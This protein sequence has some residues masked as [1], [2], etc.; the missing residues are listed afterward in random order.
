MA[1]TDQP[2][3]AYPAWLKR[4]RVPVTVIVGPHGNGVA[5][6]LARHAGPSDLVI[7]KHAIMAKLSGRRPALSADWIIPA[8]THRNAELAKLATAEGSAGVNR[9]WLIEQSPRDWQRRFWADRL[10]ADIVVLDPGIETA[11]AAA[12]AEGWEARWVDRWYL[13]AAMLDATPEA[14]ASSAD[15]GYGAR[16]RKMRD[17]LRAKEP[18]CRICLQERGERVPMTDLDHIVPFTRADGSK[19][20]KL[21]GD[22]KNH[23][24]LCGPCHAAR[25]ATRRRAEAAPGAG[26][27]GRPMDP[28][29][30]WN[31]A[32]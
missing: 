16:H 28:A 13:D 32:K 10:G 31:R 23:R 20:W 3:A 8:L 12:R 15:R 18:H 27:D 25:G 26:L 11:R 5:G 21:W 29:H 6:Y 14:R 30:P 7:D 4:A 19:D 2:A 22:P 17:T 24:P 9:A 1:I